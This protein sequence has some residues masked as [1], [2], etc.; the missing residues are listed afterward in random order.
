MPDRMHR[1]RPVALAGR[2]VTIR[3]HHLV[4]TPNQ[5]ETSRG[6]ADWLQPRS[7]DRGLGGYL[8]TLRERR[9]L[10]LLAV[11]LTTGAAIVYVLR[12]DKVYESEAGI[13]VTPVSESSEVAVSVGLLSGSVDPLRAVET[14]A[15][16]ISTTEV[17]SRAQQ[18]LK[19]VPEAS[20]SPEDLLAHVD[21]TPVAESNIVS[22]TASASDPDDAAAIANAFVDATV[23]ERTDELHTRVEERLQQLEDSGAGSQQDIS[24]LE[25]L[26]AGPD[27]TLQVATQAQPNTTPVSPRK[28]I[29][30][31]AG[32]IA[33]LV[34][35]IG[36]AFAYQALDPRLRR[37]EQLR[38]AFRL[39]ILA[40]VPKESGGRGRPISPRRLSPPS[41]EAYRTLRATLAA[42]GAMDDG[43]SNSILI[44]SPSASEGKTTTAI[45]LAESLALSGRKVIL[46]ECDLR[47]PEIGT[48]LGLSSDRGV[49]GVLLG[50]LKLEDAL[51]E[52]PLFGSDLKLLLAEQAAP[53]ASEILSLASSRNLIENATELADYVIIDSAPLSEVV[54]ALP[55]AASVDQVLLVV[56]LGRTRVRQIAE[57]G[58]LLSE[59]GITPAGFA[60][61][62]SPHASRGYYYQ[63]ERK[64][65]RDSPS[66]AGDRTPG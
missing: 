46:I 11:V 49:I 43:G 6:N 41:V 10:V 15:R 22:V 62:G 38:D 30:I 58:E 48:T 55:L 56:L 31:A 26:A 32:L 33:G 20:G 47:K 16:L 12:A 25:L 42:R 2:A 37:E 35:G 39:P 64:L 66:P 19:G 27:P 51:V 18:S 57:L 40:R 54:D 59:N 13:L 45:N 14:V 1:D 36:G 65:R 52:S 53:F 50:E 44:T 24:E 28:L 63:Q 17:A 23:Q 8:R 34:L 3:A 7:E 9:W 4:P 29:S 21:V 61:V 60:L 5:R